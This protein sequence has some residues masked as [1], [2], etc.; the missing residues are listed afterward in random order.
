LGYGPNNRAVQDKR[1]VGLQTLSGT[2]A[3][4]LATAFIK[5]FLPEGT[6]V[7]L[8]SPTWP[9][10]KNLCE[11]AGVP[12]KEYAYYDPKVKGVD[13]NGLVK[14]LEKAPEGSVVL[15]HACAH[16]PTGADLTLTQ[17]KQL[18]DLIGKKR[19]IPFFD[20]AYQG[21]TTGDC[22]KDAAAVRLFAEDSPNMM[23]AQSYAKN[24]GLYGHRIGAI[25]F[26]TQDENEAQRV[27]SQAKILAR[28]MYSSPPFSG[29]RIVDTILNTPELNSLWLREVKLMADRIATM[30]ISLVSALTKTGNPHSWKHVT[31]QLGM[32]A[33]TG[34]N[35]DQVSKLA[36]EHHIYLTK[37]GRISVAGLNTKNVDYIAQAFDAVSRNA[38]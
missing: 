28:G 26:I 38:K 3:C 5:K 20:M 35:E 18:K 16:N 14:D 17:W 21:F 37:D 30:R 24:M 34:L 12:W 6:A 7:Y 36:K 31:D 8:P 25:S 15:L 23:L 19:L 11:H 9:N 1:V 10:H 2:G 27:L 29:A 22:D 33:F 32:F 4:R 13:F